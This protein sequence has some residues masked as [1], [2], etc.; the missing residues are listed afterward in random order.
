[1]LSFG[2]ES[3]NQ[4]VLDKINKKIKVSQIEHAIN[5]CNEIG[6]DVMAHMIVGLPSQIKSTV[7]D[8]INKLIELNTNYIQVYCAVPYPKTNLHKTAS[9]RSWI[10]NNDLRFYEIDKAVMRN[11]T[12]TV[13]EIQN[14]RKWCL[15]RFYLRPKFII[16]QFLKTPSYRLILDGARFF[17]GWVQR[18]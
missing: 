1:M 13:E 16:K 5:L 8:T 10:V 4:G 9:E 14:L 18:E 6:I 12:M 15:K 3:L 7:K 11:E 2:I 17:F